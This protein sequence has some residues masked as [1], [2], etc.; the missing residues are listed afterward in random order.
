MRLQQD[1]QLSGGA[2]CWCSQSALGSSMWLPE[3]LCRS[4]R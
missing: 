3:T 1:K 4:T 2:L